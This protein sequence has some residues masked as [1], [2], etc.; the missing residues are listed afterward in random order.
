M[1]CHADGTPESPSQGLAVRGEVVG[2][3]IGGP[4]EAE[5]FDLAIFGLV[6][7]VLGEAVAKGPTGYEE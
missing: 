7:L 2:R 3:G 5:G 4:V 1:L 6:A